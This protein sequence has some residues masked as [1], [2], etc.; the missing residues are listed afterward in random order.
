MRKNSNPYRHHCGIPKK[1]QPQQKKP[2]VLVINLEGA[3][4]IKTSDPE[5]GAQLR[6]LLG[7][8]CLVIQSR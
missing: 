2:K 4:I 8:N 6:Q 1:H 5:I 3:R 7:E